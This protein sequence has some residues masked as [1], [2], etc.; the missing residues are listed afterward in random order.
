MVLTNAGITTTYIRYHS[1]TTVS[2]TWGTGIC[3]RDTIVIMTPTPSV[4]GIAYQ[5]TARVDSSTM[6][7]RRLLVLRGGIAY[8]AYIIWSVFLLSVLPRPDE[9]LQWLM[10]VGMLI[11]FLIGALL[12]LLGVIACR[13]IR[14]AKNVRQQA[15]MKAFLKVGMGLGPGLLLSVITPF[16]ISREYI[17]PIVVE[18]PTLT[19]DLVVPVAATFNLQQAAATLAQSNLPI[20]RYEWDFEGDARTDQ[21]TVLPSAST[22]YN[23]EGTYNVAVK[24]VLEN[25]MVRKAAHRLVIQ[26]A[27]ITITPPNPLREKEAVFDLSRL[28][29]NP[30][31]VVQI[32]WD[33]ESDGVVDEV[34]KK[35]ETTYTY[36]RSGRHVLTTILQ[37]QNGKSES[38]RRSFDVHEPSP[39]PFPVTM[40]T[41][42]H[43]LVGPPPFSVLFRVK[44]EEPIREVRWSF[45][46]GTTADGLRA[47]HTYE[48]TGAH[49]VV[50]KIHSMSGAL[51]ELMEVVR[52]AGK[53]QVPD[54]TFEGSHPVAQGKI[55]GASP[56][57]L[58][59]TP[60]SS[61]NNIKYKWEAP[62]A[63]EVQSTKTRLIALYRDLG[64]YTIILVA[65][66]ADHNIARIPITVT[67]HPSS[68]LIDFRMDKE[69]GI[70]PLMVTFDASIAKIPGEEITGFE[71]SFGDE[72]GDF[73]PGPAYTTH[74]YEKPGRYEITLRARTVSGKNEGTQKKTILVREPM[75]RACA[76]PSRLSGLAPLQVSFDGRCSTGATV[77]EW[78]FGDGTE[79]AGETFIHTFEE[80]G[81]YQVI[82]TVRDAEGT[83]EDT[84]GATISVREP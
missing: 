81:I 24:I 7:A 19:E 53:L 54:L 3:R 47:V 55:E 4:D 18:S 77:Y 43:L 48:R 69:G 9:G 49:P 63:V 22:V 75:F 39:L 31:D 1:A 52:V 8:L 10:V 37:M 29:K 45:G 71:W 61:A 80:P 44:T 16:M 56:L 72:G 50:S 2:P 59:L 38:Y 21:Q 68:S 12:L 78:N 83:R 27:D 33:F 70:A 42:P 65:E 6:Q 25:G 15:R 60:K 17:F 23:R 28:V 41:E 32:S 5:E 84:W 14:G 73:L 74:R 13:R 64:T 79:S 46:D 62:Q 35:P 51:A 76:V 26:Q 30:A 82:L 20:L 34:T 67:V 40:V 11:A 57:K 66:D 36:Y 58:I